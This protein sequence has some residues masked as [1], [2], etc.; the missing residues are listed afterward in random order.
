MTVK[1]VLSELE[2]MGSPAIKKVLMNHGA[3]EPFFGTKVEDQKKIQKKIKKDYQLSLDLYKTGISDAMYLAGL[4]ADEKRMTKNDLRNWAEGAYW[5]ML[6]E[7]TVPWVTAESPFGWELGLEWI[8]S[9]DEKIA[10]AGWSTL[11]NW[12]AL[13]PD[14]ELDLDVLSAF[15]DLIQEKIHSS[16]NRVKYT[17]NGFVI[18]VGA[19]VNPLSKKAIETGLHIGKVQVDLGGTAC[20]VPLAPEYIEKCITRGTLK[21]KKKMVRC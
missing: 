21:K 7:Y 15:L 18:S 17:M 14:S 1:E 4:I 11:S 16:Q 5:Y 13:K 8:E 20:K 19:Y 10:S 3:R 9:K 2:A 12:I 6:S